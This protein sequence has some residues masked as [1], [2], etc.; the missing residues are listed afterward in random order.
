ME[1]NIDTYS[2]VFPILCERYL[3]S[4][5]SFDICSGF[6]G[7]VGTSNNQSGDCNSNIR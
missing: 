7:D 3:F 4:D 5:S 1:M 6:G 2:N